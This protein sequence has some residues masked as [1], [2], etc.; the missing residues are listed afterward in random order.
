MLGSANFPINSYTAVTMSVIS[1]FVIQPSP[2]IS[3]KEKVHRS[4]SSIEP[5][6]SILRPVT[7][8]WGKAIRSFI[9]GWKKIQDVVWIYWN[10]AMSIKLC[11]QRNIS[12][13]KILA[14]NIYASMIWNLL[15]RVLKKWGSRM[16]TKIQ[17][18][19]NESMTTRIFSLSSRKV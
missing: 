4:F 5:R 14:K 2:F 1:S 15:S 13:T 17:H 3:Y 19:I 7:K 8:S 6:D 18:I 16:R 9:E 11:K 12:E 10:A